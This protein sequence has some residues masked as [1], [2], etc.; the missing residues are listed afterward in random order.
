M[1]GM[2]HPEPIAKKNGADVNVNMQE[3]FRYLWP[4]LW[5]FKGRVILAMLALIAA[6]LATLLMPWALKHVI[7]SVDPSVRPY[8]MHSLVV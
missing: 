7:D 4:Y 6:K 3:T 2:N 1:R 8:A 5:A